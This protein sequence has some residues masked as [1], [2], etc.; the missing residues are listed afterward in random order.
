[1]EITKGNEEYGL[2]LRNNGTY[3]KISAKYV[4]LS[5]GKSGT[6]WLNKQTEKLK[7]KVDQPKL[8]MG[9][10][11]ETNQ[12]ITKKL[13]DLSFDPKIS[14]H[15]ENGDYVKT[16]CWCEGGHIMSCNYQGLILLGGHAFLNEKSNNTIFALLSNFEVPKEKTLYDY[17]YQLIK[18]INE[19]V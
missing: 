13:T 17:S 15:M 11:I 16:H 5:V 12:R 7:I 10:R 1:M 6:R 18:N 4:V 19:L 9:I 3:S 2:L 8:F 14:M